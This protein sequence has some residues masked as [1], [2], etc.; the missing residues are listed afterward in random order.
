MSVLNV[1]NKRP[2]L[3]GLTGGIATGKSTVTKSLKKAGLMII[4]SDLI[5]SRLWQHDAEL[6][7]MASK[8]FKLPLPIDKRDLSRQVFSD[9]KKLERLNEMIH[10]KVFK[11]IDRL[12]LENMHKDIIVIDMPLLFEV[13]Y[14]KIDL[15]VL[16]YATKDQQLERLLKRNQMTKAKANLM[17]ASQ[18]PINQKLFMADYVIYNNDTISKLDS[19]INKFIE[20][21]GV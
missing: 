17:I 2:F 21:L 1:N 14:R 5:V 15:S 7:E 4:D 11:E 16:V 6:N 20:K 8:E 19:E 18:M 10:P 9:P 13:D 3:I 12:V